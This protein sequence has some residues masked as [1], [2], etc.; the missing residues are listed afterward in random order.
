MSKT[1][2]YF[3]M[4]GTIAD[5]YGQ[6][7]W[8]ADLIAEKPDPYKN[9]KP[10]VNM[11]RLARKLNSLQRAGYKVGIISWLSKSG[12]VEYNEVV[13]VAKRQ[14][15]AKHLASVHFD[16]IHIVA[17]GTPKETLGTGILFDDELRNREN[18]GEGAYLPEEIFEI[19]GE[20]A[21]ANS[22]RAVGELHNKQGESLCI[23]YIDICYSL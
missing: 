8:L 4:D 11:N 10:M 1:T 3:D 22:S 15:L 19:L 12:T 14:W 13:T 21:Q 5:L 20:L 18:W 16:E 6:K 17:Y 7:N 2:I 23:L 9:A